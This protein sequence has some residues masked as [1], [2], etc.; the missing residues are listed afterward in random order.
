MF[1]LFHD[2]Q[3]SNETLDSTTK[4]PLATISPYQF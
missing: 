3:T 4:V 1:N 2:Q